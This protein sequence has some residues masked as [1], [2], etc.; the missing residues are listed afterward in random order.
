M[1]PAHCVEGMRPYL[2][3]KCT[4]LRSQSPKAG[5]NIL[6][7]SGSNPI[8]GNAENVRSGKLQN[9]SFPILSHFHPEFCPGFCPEFCSEF[10]PNF[11]RIFCALF[12]GR[13]RPEKIHQKSPPFSNAKFPGKHEEHIHKILLE[14][15]Q[16]KKMRKVSLTG[17]STERKRGQCGKCG[18]QNA[19]NAENVADWF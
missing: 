5:H 19:E 8:R 13:R 9:E 6:E 7:I 16:S 17:D 1:I 12:R 14:S 15:R 2:D 11:A 10:S 18:H 3:V 4:S